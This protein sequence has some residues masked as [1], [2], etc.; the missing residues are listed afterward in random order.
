MFKLIILIMALIMQLSASDTNITKTEEEIKKETQRK[1]I[2]ASIDRVIK[3]REEKRRIEKE[4]R[5]N[6]EINWG[7]RWNKDK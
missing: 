7:W 2:A 5:F 4:N 6:Q 1:L 3:D